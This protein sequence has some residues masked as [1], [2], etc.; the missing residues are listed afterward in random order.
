MKKFVIFHYGFEMPT[1]EIMGAWSK[2]FESIGEKIVDPGSPLGNGREISRSGTKEL[3]MGLD[4]LTGYTVINAESM[5]E[6]EKIAKS[7]PMITSI[8]VY[9]AMSM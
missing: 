4:S 7:C 6:A 2:W 3:P 9:E 1:S 8:Q 5:E